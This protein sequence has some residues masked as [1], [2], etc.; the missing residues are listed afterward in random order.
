METIV[1]HLTELI[2][3]NYA[4]PA[5]QLTPNTRFEE[6]D[7]DSLVLIEL[8]VLLSNRWGVALADGELRPDHSIAEVAALLSAK[9]VPAGSGR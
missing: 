8:T 1:T 4:L 9:G 3:E 7:L 5:Q 2:A 6:L